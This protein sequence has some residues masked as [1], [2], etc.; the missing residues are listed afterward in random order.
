MRIGSKPL[1]IDAEV[2]GIER[3]VGDG[4]LSGGVSDHSPIKAAD[5]IVNL[6]AHVGNDGACGIHDDACNRGR[7]PSG[8]SLGR[9][10][11]RQ[12]RRQKRNDQQ[13]RMK[14]L[15]IRSQHDFLQ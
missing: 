4:E 14:R 3:N 2:I 1:N 6:D 15:L 11:Q 10:A 8:L 12:I 9:E 13:S 5:R 7:V